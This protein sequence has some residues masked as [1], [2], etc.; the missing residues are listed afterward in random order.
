MAALMQA[1]R[2]PPSA[3]RTCFFEGEG[4]RKGREGVMGGLHSALSR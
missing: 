4:R 2:V 3:W 1:Q